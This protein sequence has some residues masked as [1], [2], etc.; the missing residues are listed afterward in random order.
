MSGFVSVILMP[1][2]YLMIAG[3]AALA[4]IYYEK[5]DLITPAGNLDFELILPSAIKEFVPVGLLGLLLAGLLAAFMS[6]FAGTLNAAQAYIINDIY[7]NYKK[8]DVSQKQIK[9]MNYGSGLIVV[10]V[11]VILGFF[12]QDVNSIL[13]WLVSA[14]FGSYVVAN[15]LKWHWWRFNGEGFFWGMLAGMVPALILPS[16]LPG[17]LDLYYFPVL[18]A[19]SI[20]GCL[21]GTYSAP[22]TDEAILKKFYTNVR[23]WGFWKP[24][25]EKILKENPNFKKNKDFKLDMFNV[26]IGIIAQTAL[27]ILPMYMVFRQQL[28]TVILVVVL[29]ICGYLMKKYWWDKLEEKLD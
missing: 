5:L 11:S 17:T 16:L 20:I 4:L 9:I 18:L 2:R 29:I 3:F 24:I 10:T 28:P 19:T 13:Q 14:L 23:P 6:T 26:F 7:L 25:E 12:V 22:P 15:I 1:I 27:V 21:V 8:K